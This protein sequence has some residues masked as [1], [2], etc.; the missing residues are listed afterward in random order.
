MALVELQEYGVTS[1]SL[2]LA[3]VEPICPANDSEAEYLHSYPAASFAAGI[4]DKTLFN[5]LSTPRCD[6]DHIVGQPHVRQAH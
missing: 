6:G 1:S 4:T 3:P 2:L 5:R